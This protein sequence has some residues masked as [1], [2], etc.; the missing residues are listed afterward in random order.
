MLEENKDIIIKIQSIID[1]LLN[2]QNSYS[3]DRQLMLELNDLISDWDK[4]DN[5]F[6]VNY[7]D[8]IQIFNPFFDMLL[9]KLKEYENM[10]LDENDLV[11]ECFFSFNINE[12]SQKENLMEFES[13]IDSLKKIY[14]GNNLLQGIIF[15]MHLNSLLKRYMF[16]NNKIRK[17]NNDIIIDIDYSSRIMFYKE[18]Y[19][20]KFRH[21]LENGIRVGVFLD[22][23]ELIDY[24]KVS[25][26]KKEKELDI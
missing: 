25:I 12:F 10:L 14:I 3:I 23:D 13:M 22:E 26:E 16:N 6:V 4:F 17:N 9:I 24:I 5:N 2:N 1:L 7:L 8:F 15:F 21:E 20:T 18:E 19:V 11:S